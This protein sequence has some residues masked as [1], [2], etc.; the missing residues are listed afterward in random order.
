MPVTWDRL[1]K[2][3]PT[4]FTLRTAPDLLEEQGDPWSGILTSKQDLGGLLEARTA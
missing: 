2:I 4:E 3:Y 1:E